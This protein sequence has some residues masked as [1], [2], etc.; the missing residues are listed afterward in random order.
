MYQV[1]TGDLGM[2]LTVGDLKNLN[3]YLLS[4]QADNKDDQDAEFLDQDESTVDLAFLRTL[5][6]KRSRAP[7]IV[8][9]TS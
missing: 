2:D 4:L 3:R 9:A 6:P 7:T 5:L 1:L 8:Q